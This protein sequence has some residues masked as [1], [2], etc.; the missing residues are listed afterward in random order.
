VERFEVLRGPAALMYGGNATGGVVNAIDNR[1][2]TAPLIGL[3]GR[4]EMRLGGAADERAAVALVEGGAAGLNWHADVA[5]RRSDDQRVPRFAPPDGSPPRKRV[6]NSAGD[7]RSGALGVSWADRDGHI[8]MAFDEYR[9]DYGVAVEPDITIDMRRTRATLA[10]ERRLSGP[11]ERVELRA[12]RSRYQHQEI[13]GSGEIGTTFASRGQE[14]RLQLTHAPL[15]LGGGALRGT[16]GTQLE[17]LSFSALGEEAFVPGTQTRARAAYLMEQWQR[18]A[19][20]FTAGVRAERVSVASDGDAPGTTPP[21]FGDAQSRR[22]TPAS[23]SLGASWAVTP[24][25]TLSIGL[26]TTQ[27]APTYYELYANG[28]H[29][30][31]GA[32][33]VGDPTL[34]IERSRHAELGA[35]WKAGASSLQAQ[36]FATRFSRY[37]ALDATGLSIDVPNED[38]GTD[39]V[40]EYAFVAVPAR[41][42]GFEIEGRT[43]L[44]DGA[45]T[46]DASA[47]VDAVRGT[48]RASGEPL[49]RLPPWRARLAVE[50]AHGP[51][52]ASLGLRW[53]ARQSR[54]PSTDV[55]TPSAALLDASVSWRQRWDTLDALLFL[56]LD[57]LGDRLAFNAAALRT[58][59]E[60]TPLPGRSATLG[61]RLVW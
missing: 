12:S 30:A 25:A 19:V 59:R 34:G 53:L 54:V 55:P 56:R 44:V 15:A 39:A 13:E 1:I 2:P 49:P 32:F 58:A 24:E 42:V 20:T 8:G 18:D 46:L 40:P 14:L 52:S 57:N 36:V 43:R 38:G 10:G 17:R 50:S 26:G 61:L 45:W 31:T 22:F 5:A 28:V 35:Q 60:L 9:N 4:A 16:I 23:A 47:Q 27:R 7:S 21:R 51:W 11:V 41:L 6:I 29:V 33:E 37:I 48:Q 3:S